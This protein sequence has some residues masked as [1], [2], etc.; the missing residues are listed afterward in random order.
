M[1]VWAEGMSDVMNVTVE[2]RTVIE[3]KSEVKLT[4]A[5]ASVYNVYINGEF[6]AAGPAR[7]AHGYYRVDSINIGNFLKTEHN[8]ISVRVAGY[9]VNSFIPLIKSRFYMPRLF[10][11]AMS[12]PQPAL[13]GLIL[14]CLINDS[15]KPS[16]IRISGICGGLRLRSGKYAL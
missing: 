2:F 9:G 5:A 1:P 10:P 11:T 7:T 15:E 14:F 13:S 8:C 4:C 12:P 3:K 6:A 16:G